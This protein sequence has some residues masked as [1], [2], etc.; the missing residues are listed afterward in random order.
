[1]KTFFGE[2][3]IDKLK[4]KEANIYN[5]IKLEYYK[6]ENE[7]IN[8]EKYGIEITERVPILINPNKFN[9]KY[10]STKEHRMG[11]ILGGII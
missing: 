11:H 7:A 1:M 6:I 4:L 5:P 3:F 8:I 10:L 9:E 2:T